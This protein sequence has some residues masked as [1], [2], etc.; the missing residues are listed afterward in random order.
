[1]YNGRL[2][3]VFPTAA[4][5]L[6]PTQNTHI[7]GCQGPKQPKRRP[8]FFPNDTAKCKICTIRVNP[9]GSGRVGKQKIFK[10]KK[11]SIY[12]GESFGGSWICQGVTV[13]FSQAGRAPFTPCKPR[14]FR[15]G[16]GFEP[17]P[18]SVT[19]KGNQ[20]AGAPWTATC[21]LSSCQNN[22]NT[23]LNAAINC[24]CLTI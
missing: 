8:S 10:S 19:E 18:K 12:G 22:P 17:L 5:Q 14:D 24:S 3:D 13:P 11:S 6:R 9:P 21:S 7:L 23:L 4:P 15:A 16:F 20:S 1:M 2:G